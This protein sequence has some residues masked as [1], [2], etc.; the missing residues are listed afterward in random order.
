MHRIVCLILTVL[1]TAAACSSTDSIEDE[2]ASTAETI[3][4]AWATGDQSDIDAIYAEDVRMVLDGTTV[5]ESRDEIS[6]IITGAKTVG[7]TYAQVGPVAAYTGEDG[8]LYISMLVEV[9]GGGHP[10]GDPVVGFYRVRNGEVIRHV[11]MEA[12]AY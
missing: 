8:D 4:K 10:V 1:L 11:F 7:N 12:E 2:A 9:V 6:E 3:M 5:A